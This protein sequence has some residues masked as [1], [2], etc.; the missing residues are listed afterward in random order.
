[1]KTLTIRE[2]FHS[3]SLVKA[4]SPGQSLLVTSNG[5]P[6]LIVTKAERRP[7][8]TAEQWQKEARELLSTKRRK[9]ID[10]VAILRDLRK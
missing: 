10:T 8:K 7:R 5:K 2:F 1:M 9:K 4:L 6:E 3:P